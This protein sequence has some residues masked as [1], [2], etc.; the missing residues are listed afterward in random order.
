M[1][2]MAVEKMIP[3]AAWA[4]SHRVGRTPAGQLCVGHTK[5]HRDNQADEQDSGAGEGIRPQVD[6]AHDKYDDSPITAIAA[7]TGR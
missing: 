4:I 3:S 6:E 2:R 7:S 1:V 5:D